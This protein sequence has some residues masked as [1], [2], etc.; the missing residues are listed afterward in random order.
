MINDVDFQRIIN[1]LF[2]SCS[3]FLV[4][5]YIFGMRLCLMTKKRKIYCGLGF[6]VLSVEMLFE[7]SLS[8]ISYFSIICYLWLLY[9]ATGE[10]LEKCARIWMLTFWSLADL[11][12]VIHNWLDAFWVERDYWNDILTY[13]VIITFLSIIAIVGSLH[14]KIRPIET[15]AKIGWLLAF[16]MAMMTLVLVY[17]M[18]VLKFV[19]EKNYR[20]IGS[21]YILIGGVILC[22][23][24]SLIAY[25]S[26]DVTHRKEEN[27]ILQAFTY[28]QRDLFEEKL[29]IEEDTRCFRHDIKNELYIIKGLCDQKRYKEL[30]EY[31]DEILDSET[32]FS[33]KN[34]YSGNRTLDILLNA[35]LNKLKGILDI[36]VKGKVDDN[37]SVSDRDLCLIFANLL[38]NAVEAASVSGDNPWI[39][40]K[41]IQGKQSLTIF[42]E[43]S[44][45]RERV[46]E[47]KNLLDLRTTKE[48]TRLH[49]Y[50][51][52]KV[53]RYTE[54][55][56][57][58]YRTY[59]LED[60]YG[61]EVS[62][63]LVV[64]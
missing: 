49:G 19:I 20:S 36:K 30:E 41:F 4:Y 51:I 9:W 33:I 29:R 26:N 7:H 5:Y 42:V 11:E 59:F 35:Y 8:H 15:T 46:E 3:F 64:K 18:N 57:G 53:K 13:I 12:C 6:L 48:D 14:K 28:Q 55:I 58:I 25:F 61:A 63:P 44:I 31:I 34:V 50:G 56:G 24:I 52:E 45:S 23:L 43:N 40:I 10:K 2:N 17:C 37:L 38:S 16:L 1:H 60:G 62:I 47:I 32:F 21:V 39:R 27:E 22:V 54:K